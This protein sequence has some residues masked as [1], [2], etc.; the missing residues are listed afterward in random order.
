MPKII[1]VIGGTGSEGPGLALRWAKSGQYQVIIGSRQQEKAERV[2]AELN[3]QLGQDLMRG[4]VNRDAVAAADLVVLTV[5]Y[6]AHIP[7][8]ESI[9]SGLTG[10]ILVDVTVPLQPPKVS[11]VHI[12]PGGSAAA[13]AQA[14]LGDDVRVVAAFQ[15]IGA[16]HLKDPDHPIECDVL[17]CGDDKEAKAE[18]IALAEAAGMRGLDAGPLQNAVVVE[19]LTAVLIGINIRYKANKAGV[20]ITGLA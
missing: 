5:P 11:H 20:K 7:T 17:V 8:L 4:M 18:A 6:T 1:A 12:P 16:A 9:R 14:L 10:K 13:E 2:A 19:G 15:N 3:A